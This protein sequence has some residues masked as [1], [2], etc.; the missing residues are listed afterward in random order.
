MSDRRSRWHRL[1][2][3]AIACSL[4]AAAPADGDGDGD[5]WIAQV[6]EQLRWKTLELELDFEVQRESKAPFHTQTRVSALDAADGQQILM[7]FEQPS[8]LKGTAFLARTRRDLDDQYFMYLRALRRVKRIPRCAD[9]YRLRDF[10]SLYLLK[11]R[12][13]L[14]RFSVVGEPGA[15][16][17]LEGRPRSEKTAEMTGY[18]RVVHTV[19]PERRVIVRSE[20]YDEKGTRIRE[21]KVTEFSQEGGFWWPAAFE[22]VDETEGVSA[23]VKVRRV[24]IDPEIPDDVFSVRGLKRR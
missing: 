10:M 17:V 18:A 19:D 21:Q 12:T 24:R 3:L 22:T 15:E 13:E 11:P 8:H 4:V 23:R 9:N 6:A 1:A 16:V 5:H 14:W 20:F 7:A 2:L